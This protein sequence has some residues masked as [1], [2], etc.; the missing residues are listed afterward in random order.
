MSYILDVS[1]RRRCPLFEFLKF[2]KL[3]LSLEPLDSWVSRSV[4]KQKH[5]KVVEMC[6][7]LTLSSIHD[8]SNTWDG[9]VTGNESTR[10][11]CN[12]VFYSQYTTMQHKIL[13][14]SVKDRRQYTDKSLTLE[15]SAYQQGQHC[16]FL[17]IYLFLLINKKIYI[18]LFFYLIY[19]NVYSNDSVR[20]I[21]NIN[22]RIKATNQ[23]LLTKQKAEFSRVLI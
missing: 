23:H 10:T 8:K 5:L 4:F 11:W 22:M 15:T 12:H 9:A 2:P 14:Y 20:N 17:F 19:L 13:T 21:I 6:Q 18:Y 7:I 1:S 16:M 3:V